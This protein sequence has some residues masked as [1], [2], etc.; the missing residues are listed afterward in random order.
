VPRGVATACDADEMGTLAANACAVD[1]FAVT[2]CVGLPSRFRRGEAKMPDLWYN[3]GRAVI[4]GVCGFGDAHR[5]ACGSC[6][7]LH[8]DHV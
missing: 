5:M 2:A 1:G 3:G 4:S 6:S 7:R 8:G